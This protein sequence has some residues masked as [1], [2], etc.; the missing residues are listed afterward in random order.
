[1]RHIA[2]SSPLE[3]STSA[4]NERTD[5]HWKVGDERPLEGGEHIHA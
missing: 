3:G 4:Y 5:K 2:D 1:M